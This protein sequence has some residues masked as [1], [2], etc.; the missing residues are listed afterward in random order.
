[1]QEKT[2]FQQIQ[3]L[4]Q[5]LQDTDQLLFKREAIACE[6]KHIEELLEKKMLELA[7]RKNRTSAKTIPLQQLIDEGKTNLTRL[8]NKLTDLDHLIEEYENHPEL[9]EQKKQLL[10]EKALEQNPQTFAQFQQ[11]QQREDFI[12]TLLLDLQK[13]IL[14]LSDMSKKFDAAKAALDKNRKRSFLEWLFGRHGKVIAANY[15][16][17][18]FHDSNEIRFVTDVDL[19]SE[20]F[21]LWSDY[22]SYF[23]TEINTTWKQAEFNVKF[24]SIHNQF[25]R[26]F[27]D[28][29]LIYNSWENNLLT[30]KQLKEEWMEINGNVI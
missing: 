20:H 29:K 26:L 24:D 22:F 17:Q 21:R 18:I 13:K 23:H 14:T 10:L 7:Y 9:I 3:K 8:S 25:D 28:L 4:Q 11:L 5:E 12:V 19:L 1:M 6:K 16:V 2:V 30:V 27:N 15:L